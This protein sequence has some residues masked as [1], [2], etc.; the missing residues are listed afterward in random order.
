MIAATGKD[1]DARERTYHRKFGNAHMD[2]SSNLYSD[3]KIG[4][5][6]NK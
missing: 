3:P 1:R 6:K 5:N 4:Q 2:L